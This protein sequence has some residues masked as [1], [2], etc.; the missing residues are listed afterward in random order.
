MT[1]KEFSEL[2][3]CTIEVKSG[4]SGKIL[5]RKYDCKKHHDISD[6]EII[7]VWTEIRAING[8][9]FSSYAKPVI[10]VFVRRG[11]EGANE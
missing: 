5:C 6:R 3:H 10:C 4:Y 8:G 2:S 9:G 1:V 7:S 11:M